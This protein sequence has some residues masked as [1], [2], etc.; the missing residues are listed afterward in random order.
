MR[1]L[2]VED[3]AR[4]RTSLTDGLRKA[5]YAVDAA[6]DGR[7]GLIHARTTEYDVIVLD[8]M[9]PEIDGLTVLQTLRSTGI[10]TPVLILSARDRT[11]HR[12]Q[13]L[14]A[15][16][17]DYLVKPFDFEELLARIEVLCRRTRDISRS[18]ISCGPLK[19]DT[20]A[21]RVSIQDMPIELTRREYSVIEYLAL[22]RDRTVSRAELEE[23]I[24]DENQQVWS[25]AIDS[26]IA[27]IRRKLLN[28]GVENV[29][30]LIVTRRGFGYMLASQQEN[31]D[32]R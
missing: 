3:S 20:S 28:A 8:L 32:K 1:V 16:A 11:E 13:G 19:L 18:S 25:N 15:G 26:T 6:A 7:D 23:H 27:A 29:S 2:V 10:A 17:D 24:Y 21:K 30:Q 9:L 4:L 5:G 12:V 31:A 22:S 14:R